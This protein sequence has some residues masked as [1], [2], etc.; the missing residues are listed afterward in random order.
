MT[1]ASSSTYGIIGRT[2]S[3]D[4][5]WDETTY[6]KKPTTPDRVNMFTLRHLIESKS[7]GQLHTQVKVHGLLYLDGYLDGAL[8]TL[9]TLQDQLVDVE[10]FFYPQSIA[11]T[12]G[13]SYAG[14]REI[15]VSDYD[16]GI[17]DTNEFQFPVNHRNLQPP[18]STALY[19][20]P[21]PGKA[22]ILVRK[23]ID[24]GVLEK[25]V[26][27][28]LESLT[29]LSDGVEMALLDD[30][31]QQLIDCKMSLKEQDWMVRT[32]GTYF[33]MVYWEITRNQQIA[34]AIP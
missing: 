26:G 17:K 15:T 19:T 33:K 9:A 20:I 21:V 25:E 29:R 3:A 11:Y 27:M 34:S 4:G 18:P 23:N 5:L 32:H 14:W 6:R 8:E 7:T 16:I 24:L 13:V 31:F 30:V 1:N 10:L 12:K 2:T 22:S 28:P